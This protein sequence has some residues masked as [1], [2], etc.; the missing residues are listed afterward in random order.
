MPSSLFN[1][2]QHIAKLES[3]KN[4][5]ENFSTKKERE[6]KKRQEKLMIGPGE[7]V[8]AA[9]LRQRF[10][11]SIFFNTVLNCFLC[12]ATPNYICL[13][14]VFKLKIFFLDGSKVQPHAAGC[15]GHH[16]TLPA[17]ELGN[18]GSRHVLPLISRVP[19][20]MSL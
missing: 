17:E 7:S 19:P 13:Q 12:T 1:L 8:K 9:I 10:F 5:L 16:L 18:W 11:A 2:S 4:T 15:H 3:L 6:K 14:S 20:V